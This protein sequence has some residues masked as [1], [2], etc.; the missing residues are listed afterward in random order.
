M[1]HLNL[2][3]LFALVTV[4]L[5]A[6]DS[7]FVLSKYEEYSTSRGKALKTMGR[8]IGQIRNTDIDVLVTTD[9]KR[10]DTVSVVR[11]S[12]AIADTGPWI[13]IDKEEVPNLIN[14]LKYYATEIK[15]GSVLNGV[16]YSYITP[17]DVSITC[18]YSPGIFSDTYLKFNKIYRNLRTTVPQG[19][20][21]GKR[22]IEGLIQLL[23]NANNAL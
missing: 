22:D 12:S 4:C 2:F 11:L 10:G 9:I 15:N 20:T 18:Y 19:H 6:Q 8:T 14:L 21:F 23:Q 5:Q 3:L 1:K 17:N 13:F 16:Y 7:T